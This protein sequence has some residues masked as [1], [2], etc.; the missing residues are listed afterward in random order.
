MIENEAYTL[1]YSSEE[2]GNQGA[3]GIKILVAA[4]K[5]PDLKSDAIRD[6]LYTAVGLVS[7]EIKAAIIELNPEEKEFTEKEREQLLSVFPE[8]IFYEAIPNGYCS[9]WCCRHKPWYIVTT[10]VGHFK[11]GWR[12]RVIEIDWSKIRNPQKAKDLFPAEDV[13]KGDYYIHAWSV[14]DAKKYIDKILEG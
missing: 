7:S 1:L 4:D 13:T 5:L 2:F 11:I 9:D 6:A 12:K 8:H 10:K 14:K 3:F